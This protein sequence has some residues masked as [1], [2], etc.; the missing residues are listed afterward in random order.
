MCNASMQW[1]A[2]EIEVSSYSIRDWDSASRWNNEEKL[3]S[4]HLSSHEELEQSTHCLNSVD[5]NEIKSSRSR[6]A[7]AKTLNALE[8]VL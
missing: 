5:N 8:E 7:E 1:T 4:F 6:F 2:K 3:L